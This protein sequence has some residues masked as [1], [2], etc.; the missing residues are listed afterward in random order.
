M[1][2]RKCCI[3]AFAKRRII[4]VYVLMEN[5][6][7]MKLTIRPHKCSVEVRISEL[8]EIRI[9]P[10]HLIDRK[11]MP[12]IRIIEYTIFRAFSSFFSSFS[13][14]CSSSFSL[15]SSTM[16]YSFLVK[17]FYGK[18]STKKS[19]KD[20]SRKKDMRAHATM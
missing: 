7:L 4:F 18:K 15:F 11:S 16:V 19:K 12:Q 1:S 14:L 13:S 8:S 17:K 10:D 20:N 6:P 2:S 5:M 3:K 9:Y